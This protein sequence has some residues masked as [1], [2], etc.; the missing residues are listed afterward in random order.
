[1]AHLHHQW[2]LCMPCYWF[3]IECWMIHLS[4]FRPPEVNMSWGN[5]VCTMTSEEQ[6][7]K[8]LW[9]FE[10]VIIHR[11]NTVLV[12]HSVLLKVPREVHP[13]YPHSTF[14]PICV[15]PMGTGSI[16]ISVFVFTIS[17]TRFAFGG[18]NP[19]PPTHTHI[20]FLWVKT[21]YSCP[22]LMGSYTVGG[23]AQKGQA[24]RF[25]S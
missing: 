12:Y 17:S 16:H 1:M 14:L 23:G 13:P 5:C 18:N 7:G 2:K 25:L 11:W 19:P 3:A 6:S 8:S 24:L 22:L 4:L 21:S 20:L 15:L 10:A 9:S